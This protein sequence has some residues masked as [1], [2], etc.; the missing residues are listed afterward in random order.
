MFAVDRLILLAAVLVLGGV[1]SSKFSYR[2]GL[3]VLL[4]FLGVGMLAGSEGI[5]GLAFEDYR[6]AH[7]VGTLALAFILFDGGL[8]TPLSAFRAASWPAASLATAGVVVTALVTG[9]CASL[10]LNL[11]WIEGLLI[12]SIV[13]STD[14]AAVF[15]VLRS[16]GVRIRERIAATLEIESGAND[17]MAIFLTIGCLEI[18]TGTAGSF[19]GLVWLF[20]KQMTLGAVVGLLG[21]WSVVWVINRVNLPA[22]GL[23]P[24][25]VA[26]GALLVF[27]MAASLGGSGFLAVYLAGLVVGNNRIVFQRGIFVFQDALAWLSQIGMFVVLGLL[28]FPSRLA[29]V[30]WQGLAVAAVLVFVARPV[31]VAA[32]LLPFKFSRREQLFISWVGLKG[33][34]PI[35][36][37]TFPFLFEIPNALLVFDI[38]FFTV[39]V[40]V[41]AQGWTMPPLARALGLSL[42]PLPEPPATLEIAALRH[43]DSH[44]VDYTVDPRSRA[45]GRRIRDLALPDGAVVALISRGRQVIP[46]QGDTELHAGDHV[47]LVLRSEVQPIVDQ[48]F[49][50]AAESPGV[51]AEIE[52]PLRGG[53]T[54]EELQAMYGIAIDAAPSKTLDEVLRDW[55]GD[56]LEPGSQVTIGQVALCVRGVEDG[57][58]TRVGLAILAEPP[59]GSQATVSP[60]AAEPAAAST[61]EG[62][63]KRAAPAEPAD[64]GS[65]AAAAVKPA[66]SDDR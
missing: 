14:A 2:L 56:E 22:A 57:R 12:G 4:V 3:P 41:I 32:C 24:V 58:V 62:D 50:P 25:F 29:E 6:L 59:D 45:V 28:S 52:F 37:A 36:L 13:G 7:A 35:V 43:V 31:A 65:A 60:K 27:G 30:T 47:S 48:V 40:S 18:L 46:P 38:V 1:V 49:A 53:T 11:P 66:L 16:Q 33:A 21:G 44:I 9:I 15:A 19:F 64:A 55:L 61:A 42:P 34:V 20:V 8:R 51:P 23:Y 63:V 10:I 54:V 26:A 5:G 39:L 17:P